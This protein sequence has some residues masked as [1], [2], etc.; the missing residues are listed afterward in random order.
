MRLIAEDESADGSFLDFWATSFIYY[1]C[2]LLLL[3][4]TITEQRGGGCRKPHEHLE[5]KT[6]QNI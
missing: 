5:S 4:L 6:K 3:G 2:L 1:I